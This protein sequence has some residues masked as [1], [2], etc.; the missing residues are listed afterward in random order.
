MEIMDEKLREV[1]EIMDE[2][3]WT[4]IIDAETNYVVDEFDQDDPV[5]GGGPDLCGGC[6]DCVVMQ[7]ESAGEWT[8]HHDVTTKGLICMLMLYQGMKEEKR[9]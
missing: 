5:C 2:K 6:R 3:L 7:C 1:M 4:V 8:I 9:S